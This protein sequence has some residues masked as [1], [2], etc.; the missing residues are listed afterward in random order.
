MLKWNRLNCRPRVTNNKQ[1]LLK[2]PR[3]SSF[4]PA[5]QGK[6][7]PLSVLGNPEP[8]AWAPCR[9]VDAAILEVVAN[10]VKLA[11]TRRR[12]Q[13][14][15][16]D[17]KKVGPPVIRVVEVQPSLE[18]QEAGAE[19]PRLRIAESLPAF[20]L[21]GAD[22]V[23]G[24]ASLAVK[25]H[26]FRYRKTDW[27]KMV[28]AFCCGMI[29]YGNKGREVEAYIIKCLDLSVA[30]WHSSGVSMSLNEVRAGLARK[31]VRV[32]DEIE[33]RLHELI[34]SQGHPAKASPNQPGYRVVVITLGFKSKRKVFVIFR[35]IK[36]LAKIKETMSFTAK[37]KK[38]FTTTIEIVSVKSARDFRHNVKSRFSGK[39]R[40]SRRQDERT[41]R[42][43]HESERWDFRR[44]A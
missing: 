38:K 14:S 30:E 16:N 44:T 7:Q 21:P 32:L 41:R 33:D 15:Q 24:I 42:D 34:L 36:R 5:G 25:E 39:E 28:H 26:Y 35:V 20:V 2:M 9:K 40:Y 43:R 19:Q 29:G 23:R 37:P 22:V 8:I 13:S 6:V 27:G 12:S 31:A 11:K 4:V 10:N 1:G 18:P 3:V 17:P